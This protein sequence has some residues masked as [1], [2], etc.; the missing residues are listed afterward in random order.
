MARKGI[1]STHKVYYGRA[2]TTRRRLL[3]GLLVFIVLLLAA[4]VG[5]FFLQEYIVATPEGFRFE[6]PFSQ[7]A[8]GAEDPASSPN[9]QA[10]APEDPDSTPDE[11]A[12]PEEPEEEPESFTQ[13]IE[14]DIAQVGDANYRAQLLTQ[15][16]QSGANTL[17]FTVKDANGSVYIPTDSALANQIGAVAADASVAE[18]L[19]ALRQSGMHL[20]ARLSANRDNLGA[21][22]M[23]DSALQTSSGAIWL[24]YD[25]IPWLA[26]SG[27]QTAEYLGQLAASCQQLGFDG[28]LLTNVGYPVRGRTNLI[29]TDQNADKAALVT[30]MVS[31][32]RSRVPDMT[33]AIELT[34]EAATA[35]SDANSGQVVNSLKAVCDQLVIAT[36]TAEDSTV[37]S[38]RSVVETQDSACRVAVS[39]PASANPRSTERN[40]YLR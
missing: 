6:F 24:D 38:L 15:A 19:Q 30:Q 5:F 39:L 20:T 3:I 36:D 2:R 22:G 40:Y 29:T 37:Q 7:P 8:G 21:R 11:P 23:R 9:G 13:A 31:S 27:A 4:V 26:P 17:V 33:L 18:G 10:D 16:Q 12:A 32:I 35:F 1:N 28:L 14:G 25:M 34:D